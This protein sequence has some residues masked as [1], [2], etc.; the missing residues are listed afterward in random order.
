M[1]N[2]LSIPKL[3]PLL[4]DDDGIMIYIIMLIFFHTVILQY[5]STYTRAFNQLQAMFYSSECWEHIYC[6][7]FIFI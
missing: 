6:R 3:C 2:K 7:V 4:D 5:T 1:Y